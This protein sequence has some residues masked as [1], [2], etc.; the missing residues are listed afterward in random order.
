MPA[1]ASQL[2]VKGSLAA[3]NKSRSSRVLVDAVAVRVS[4]AIAAWVTAAASMESDLA[5]VAACSRR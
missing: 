3:S 4:V 5:P 1:L 2:L